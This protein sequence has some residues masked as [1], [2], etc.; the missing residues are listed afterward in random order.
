M[1]IQKGRAI[2]IGA[3]ALVFLGVVLILV[4]GSKG[5]PG[6][7]AAPKLVIWGV[8]ERNNFSAAVEAYNKLRGGA[9][10][11]SYV[12]LD[13]KNY[14]N[15]LIRS[16]AEQRGPDIF[17]V[18]NHSVYKL[19]NLMVPADQQTLNAVNLNELFP[20]AV[21]QD[22]LIGSRVF[23][24]PLYLDTLSLAYNRDMFDRA[25]IISPP[26]TWE[27]FAADAKKLKILNEKSQIEVAGAAMGGSERSVDHA[28]DILGML[29]IQ[30]G[31]K[32]W[33]EDFSRA[34]FAGGSNTPG[35]Q[36][37]NFYLSFSNPASEN[38][39]WNDAQKSSIDAFA[40]GRAAMAFVYADDVGRIK[41]ASPYLNFGIAPVPQI[42]TS[43]AA[44]FPDYQGL[45]V[46]KQSRYP[47]GAWD[48]VKFIA[49]ESAGSYAYLGASGRPPALRSVIAQNLND[50]DLGVFI[51]QSLIARSWFTPDY[52]R[53]K[54]LFNSAIS[55]VI[56]GQ[57]DLTRALKEAEEGVTAL[58]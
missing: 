50:A 6:G 43:S 32:M 16:F 5:A 33:T 14:E 31:A 52:D 15:E 35:Y 22:F 20:S 45:S 24:L 7:V 36:A 51:R 28:A 4:F 21:S 12:A 29:M 49:T 40:S 9:T 19:A 27:E 34:A 8:D 48:F 11:V 37:A 2:A 39:T 55:S 41:R 1:P 26:A 10:S 17:Y 30:N 58:R 54:T 44:V 23:G 18:S 53:I 42:A 3:V 57:K 25:L 13:P 56:S 46:S 47:A 38:Y